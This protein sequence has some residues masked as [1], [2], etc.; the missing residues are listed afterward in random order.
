[1]V[2]LPI[3]GVIMVLLGLA[4][5]L[6]AKSAVHEIEGLICF[7]AACV[8][9]GSYAIVYS[10]NRIQENLENAGVTQGQEVADNMTSDGVNTN[11]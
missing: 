8:L 1:M 9:F 5:F 4:T 7:L 6:G 2:A 3:F 10:I 11:D